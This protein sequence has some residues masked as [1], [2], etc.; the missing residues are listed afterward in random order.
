VK[1]NSSGAAAELRFK[2][3]R[4]EHKLHKGRQG[5]FVFLRDLCAEFQF[6]KSGR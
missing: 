4:K 6:P 1:Y 2:I 3:H 5:P